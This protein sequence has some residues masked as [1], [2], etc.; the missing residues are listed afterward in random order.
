MLG[1]VVG[2]VLASEPSLDV[3]ATA[4]EGAKRPAIDAEWRTL[5]AQTAT[6][7][8]IERAIEGVAFVVNAIGVIKPY[9]DESDQASVERAIAVNALFPHRLAAAAATTGAKVIQIATDCVYSGADGPYA[10]DAAPDALDV[11]GK[12]KSLGEVPSDAMMHLRCSIIGPQIGGAQSL[13][14]WFLSQPEGAEVNGFTNHRWN[15]V[16]T[17]QFA[18]LSRGIVAADAFEAGTFHVIPGDDISKAE[19]LDSF[20]E[21][22]DRSDITV[23]HGEAGVAVDRRLRTSNEDTNRRLWE[24]AGYGEAPGVR[25]MVAEMAAVATPR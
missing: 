18:R 12:T 5:D 20:A 13:L 3:V 14:E 7:G 15:G 21:S 11:Y 23:N 10:E 2:D 19:L 4:R 25:A 22:F 1:H 17:L 6:T 9:I 16:T 24:A 8:D